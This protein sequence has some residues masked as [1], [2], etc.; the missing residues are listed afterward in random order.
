M[1]NQDF[2]RDL[3]DQSNV[4]VKKVELGPHG[5]R[6]VV[7]S[8]SPY[9]GIS[10]QRA[11]IWGLAAIVIGVSS[12]NSIFY[13]GTQAKILIVG[14]ENNKSA[15]ALSSEP[16]DS[17]VLGGSND[18]DNVSLD[19]REIAALENSTS[20]G[21]YYFL[22]EKNTSPRVSALSFAV[23][24]LD[25]GE[26]IISKNPEMILQPA[27]V[28][29]LL[30]SAVAKENISLHQE[31]IVKASALSPI[32]TEGEL[33]AGQKLLLTDILYPLLMESSNDAA[34]V[35]A[36]NF[37]EG[38]SA[39]IEKINKKARSIGMVNSSF[40]E[41]SGVS[42]NNNTTAND[43]L[44][45]GTYIYKKHKEILDITRVKQYAI[46]GHIWMNGNRMMQIKTFLGGKNGYTEVA[47]ETTLTFFNIQIGKVKRN[48]LLTILKSPSRKNDADTIVRFIQNN[49]R[50]SESGNL[51]Q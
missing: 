48:I 18:S 10:T 14:N 50:Y 13:L 4:Y 46:S 11:L 38:R 22:S 6:I 3:K 23:A 26:T 31:L 16:L 34:E 32:N 20:T 33:S 17:Q 42:H 7:V 49:M 24:D 39:F 15:L 45:L 51:D 36:Q 25:T 30:T 12:M 2:K 47:G 1:D 9:H 37:V 28:T 8:D 5:E 29:K 27:S 41:P 35:I 40:V 43:L 19:D 21:K 44:K